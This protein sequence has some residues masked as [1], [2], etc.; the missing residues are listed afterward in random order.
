M[1]TLLELLN[2]VNGTP[3][4]FDAV[5]LAGILWPNDR[6]SEG[7]WS[8]DKGTGIAK[9]VNN[10]RR[11]TFSV[12][13]NN[14]ANEKVRVVV[15]KKGNLYLL[16]SSG[17]VRTGNRIYCCG[18]DR[19][20]N[21]P[22][23]ALISDLVVGVFHREEG[24][25]VSGTIYFAD[26]SCKADPL[27][28]NKNTTFHTIYGLDRH[29]VVLNET[30]LGCIYDPKGFLFGVIYNW[31]QNKSSQLCRCNWNSTNCQ[32]NLNRIGETNMWLIELIR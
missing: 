17:M 2:A 3:S 16:E 23:T 22:E 9:S 21:V 13:G 1:K 7:I 18:L 19:F 32:A 10:Q 30:K 24:E 31:D 14:K 4:E 29:L 26:S 20:Y 15:A 28:I 8:L 25:F 12:R 6:F 5:R 27:I 11:V